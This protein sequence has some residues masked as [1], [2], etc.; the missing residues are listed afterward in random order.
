MLLI[1]Y[2]LLTGA[3][4]GVSFVALHCS[5]DG[6]RRSG[7]LGGIVSAA[8]RPFRWL[9]GNAILFFVL[10]E[11]YAPALRYVYCPGRRGRLSARSVFL[12]KSILYGAFV[13][14]RRALK[15]QKRRFPA[16]AVGSLDNN[17]FDLLTR[18]V[19]RVLGTPGKCDGCARARWAPARCGRGAAAWSVA[20]TTRTRARSASWC[21]LASASLVGSALQVPPPRQAGR[22]RPRGVRHHAWPSLR[23]PP[24]LLRLPLTHCLA[25]RP[26]RQAALALDRV[27]T[28]C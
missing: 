3:I 9:G 5:V 17:A 28:A 24:G 4:A 20:G 7:T 13:W 10:H 6:G 16:R 15:H 26:P 21:S 8:G 12:C 19:Q 25:L 11:L 18:G 23:A 1:S 27:S 14:A 2:M 22:G